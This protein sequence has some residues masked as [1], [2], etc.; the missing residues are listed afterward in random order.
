MVAHVKADEASIGVLSTGERLTV[1]LIFDKPELWT[2]YRYTALEAV[3]R[4]G[5]E[6]TRA[7]FQ[8]QRD[9]DCR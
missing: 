7:A 6:W 8:V 4:I 9:L 3:D 2:R 1:A 5:L